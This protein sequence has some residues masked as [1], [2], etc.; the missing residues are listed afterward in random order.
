MRGMRVRIPSQRWLCE[1]EL[2]SAFS[3]ATKTRSGGYTI[4]PLRGR[5]LGVGLSCAGFL[6]C[7]LFARVCEDSWS[8]LKGSEG[9]E[10]PATIRYEV[11][12]GQKTRKPS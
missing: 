3:S 7:S 10:L 8:R 6:I 9:S 5:Q 11:S 2:V 4:R 12:Q 1:H